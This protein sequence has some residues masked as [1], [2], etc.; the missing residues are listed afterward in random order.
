MQSRG[1]L[2]LRYLYAID[3]AMTAEKQPIFPEQKKILK[4]CWRVQ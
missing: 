4:T 1:S 2:L 3:D